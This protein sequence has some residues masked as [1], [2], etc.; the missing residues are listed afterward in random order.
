[1]LYWSFNGGILPENAQDKGSGLL[2]LRRIN[3]NNYG[4]YECFGTNSNKNIEMLYASSEVK[5]YKGK[6][7]KHCS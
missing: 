2:L 1:M 6:P 3:W 5:I 7:A 4:V